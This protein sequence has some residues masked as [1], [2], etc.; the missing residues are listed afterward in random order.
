MK[1]VIKCPKCELEYEVETAGPRIKSKCPNCEEVHEVVISDP[2]AET[3]EGEAPPVEVEEKEEK[4]LMFPGVEG[5][6]FL[7]YEEEEEADDD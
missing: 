1:K 6:E 3:V 5:L 7:E 2:T 4:N